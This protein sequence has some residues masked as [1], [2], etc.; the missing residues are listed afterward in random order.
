MWVA[1]GF[2]DT[3]VVLAGRLLSALVLLIVPVV[4]VWEC[5]ITPARLD[6]EHR[7]EVE[8]L[9]ARLKREADELS[10]QKAIDEIA[11]E[12]AWAV[13]NLINPTPIPSTE[14]D[15][16]QFQAKTEEWY[17]RVS[18]KLADRSV[19]ALGDQ[20]HFESL[21]SIPLV[22]RY[23]NRKLDWLN[24]ALVLKLERLREIEQRARDRVTI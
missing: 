20:V 1:L 23:G 14:E 10:R 12:I 15:F 6:A 19:F 9:Q 2:S 24:S 8:Q 4:F 16:T 21:G 7:F 18:S 3:S 17:S 5:V 13:N 11:K 22:H